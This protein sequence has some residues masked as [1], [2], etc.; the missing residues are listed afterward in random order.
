MEGKVS[1]P[2]MSS[3]KLTDVDMGLWMIY[4]YPIA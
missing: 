3:R 1:L 2:W 4:T